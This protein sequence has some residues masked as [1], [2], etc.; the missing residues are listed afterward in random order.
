MT[1]SLSNPAISARR[2]ERVCQ[3]LDRHGHNPARLIPVLQAV[4][5]ECRYLPEE[6]LTFVATALDVPPAHLY[7]VAS[8]Y[9]HFALDRVNFLVGGAHNAAAGDSAFRQQGILPRETIIPLIA[10]KLRAAGKLVVPET[11]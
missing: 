1:S 6:V 4:Q 7:G 8:F 3:I 10:E 11:R 5:E 9:A 2:F